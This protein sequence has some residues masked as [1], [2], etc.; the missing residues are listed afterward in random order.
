MAKFPFSFAFTLLRLAAAATNLYVSS[1]DGNVTSLSLNIAG[2]DYNLSLISRYQ[3]CGPSPSWL[4]WDRENRSLYCLDEGFTTPNGSI[5]SYR[6]DKSGKLT[7]IEHL[8]LTAPAAV[9]GVIF[10]NQSFRG[11]AIA[12]YTG[13]LS[14]MLLG[15]EPFSGPVQTINFTVDS[16]PGPNAARQ[17][18]PHPHQAIL[19][20]TA[21]YILVPDLG[22]DI[23]RVFCW[24][25]DVNNNTL[26]E[27]PPLEVQKGSGPRHAAF[28]S[29]GKNSTNSTGIY[30]LV[31]TELANT[32]TSYEV[33]YPLN[34]GLGF[35]EVYSTNTFGSATIPNNTFAGEIAV[36]P[37]KRYVVVSNRGDQSF[38]I[39]AYRNATGRE[40]SDSLATYAINDN[41]TLSFKQIWPAGGLFPRHFSFNKVGDLVAVALQHSERVVILERDVKSGLIGIAVADEHVS[42]NAT[43]V[44]WDED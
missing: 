23:V 41:G 11:Y 35:S 16:A 28:W 12:H 32:I 10:G 43:C 8:N 7:M 44:V 13:Q 33:N 19:D 21:E 30:L 42:G 31:V 37:D 6:A 9:A 17:A 3:Q 15:N 18:T 1:Y 34:G 36:S 20:P 5:T 27:H 24:G 40:Y 29:S 38:Q 25:P 2:S 39:P 26:I 22:Q 14:V 4:T